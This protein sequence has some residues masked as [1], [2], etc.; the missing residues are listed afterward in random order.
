MEAFEA[1]EH[2]GG[3]SR[4]EAFEKFLDDPDYYQ[5]D[6]AFM[7]GKAFAYYYPIIERYILES[8]IDNDEDEI[9]PIWILAHCINSQFCEVSTVE[10]VRPLRTRILKLTHYVR[11]H[12]PKFC[13]EQNRQTEID[14]AWSELQQKLTQPD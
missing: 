8:E 13:A 2:F 5:E 14:L 3:L 11:D 7:G 4:P 6:F 12:L 10:F 9:D 1:W